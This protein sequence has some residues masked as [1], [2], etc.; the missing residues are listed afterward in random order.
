MS[1]PAV[2]KEVFSVLSSDTTS[3]L[4]DAVPNSGTASISSATSSHSA[5]SSSSAT[6]S[7]RA[8]SSSSATSSHSAASSAASAP[9]CADSSV[10]D[11]EDSKLSDLLT[12]SLFKLSLRNAEEEEKREK[13]WHKTIYFSLK[14]LSEEVLA[15]LLS[16]LKEICPNYLEK[17]E[18]QSEFHITVLFIKKETEPIFSLVD[19]LGKKYTATIV[20]IGISEDF[21]VLG[22]SNINDEDGNDMPYYGNPIKH[23]TIGKRKNK[24]LQPANSYHALYEKNSNVITFSPVENLE[25]IL[26][27]VS[28][29]VSKK[30]LKGKK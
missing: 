21:I 23:I 4:S 30:G 27:N 8:A 10:E 15:L 2:V 11:T 9:S 16:I 3:K 17:Y 7:H 1:K 25:G 29:N 13:I 20:S 19:L 12:E 28:R 18:I 14:F 6:L 5:A 24:E 26:G 22:V